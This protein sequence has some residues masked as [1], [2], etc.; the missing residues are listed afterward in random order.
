MMMDQKNTSYSADLRIRTSAELAFEALSTK[1]GAWWG[2]QDKAVKQ[3]GDVFTVSWGEPWYQFKVVAFS[4]RDSITWECID[5][6]QII[7]DLEGVEKE[8]VGTQIHWTIKQSSAGEIVLHFTH[9][10]LVPE[11][12]CY[13][14]CSRTWDRFLHGNLKDYLERS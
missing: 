7:A 5:A 8:W 6:K 1:I 14:F 4:P 3:L 11:F 9:E 10:G 13:D 2:D 12:T